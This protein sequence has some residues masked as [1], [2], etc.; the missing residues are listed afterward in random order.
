MDRVP[1]RV[2]ALS[3]A[4]RGW[5][6][7]P[8]GRD[9]LPKIRRWHERASAD[10]MQVWAWWER[11]PQANIGCATGHVFDV[12]DL[13]GPEARAAFEQIALEA[14]HVFTGPFTR[15]GRPEGGWQL[16][17]APTGRGN[18][19]PRHGSKTDFRGR[20]G[21]V[22]LPPSI[23]A[24]GHVYTW[25]QEPTGEF[26]ELPAEVQT[27]L[28]PKPEAPRIHQPPPPE[29]APHDR[30]Q[31]WAERALDKIV[32]ELEATPRGKGQRNEAL[33]R[34]GFRAFQLAHI[35][36]E[37]AVYT[38]LVKAAEE[39]GYIADKG[40]RRTIATIRSAAVAG[41]AQPRYPVTDGGNY[42]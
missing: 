3:Y 30:L 20:G 41:L 28:W 25:L 8:V 6:V 36:G 39:I 16:F 33:N 15:T 19:R 5:P 18:R 1:M 32:E 29:V 26:P 24:S 12:V 9:K 31:R 40:E 17:Y 23:H 27:R 7:F 13:D 21:F 2:H 34:Y 37:Q 11:W 22:I 4:S 42:R 14:H 38:A 35:L 10:P